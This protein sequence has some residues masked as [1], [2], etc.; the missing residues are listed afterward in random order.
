MKEAVLP[1]SRFPSADTLLGPEMRS[2]GEVMGIDRDFAMAF[3][4]SQLGAGQNLPSEGNIFLSLADK[5]KPA[6]VE[7]AKGLASLGFN[8]VATSGTADFLKLYGIGVA[9]VVGK[10][11][12]TK[13]GELDAVS[14]IS[15]GSV[16]LV[17]NT[18]RGRGPRGDGYHIRTAANKFK[19][20][21]ITTMSAALAAVR[22]L[23]AMA[24]GDLVVKSIQEH[25]AESA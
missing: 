17:V 4:K 15:S 6:G 22:A 25:H 19:V 14:L 12:E 18:P 20:P 11:G 21:C 23:G 24:A 9:N 5:D 3:A 7:L 1:F 16:G 8:L 10:L 2:T 13:E